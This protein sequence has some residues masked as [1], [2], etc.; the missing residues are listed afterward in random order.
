MFKFY[1]KIFFLLIFANF[2]FACQPNK[3]NEKI[4]FDLSSL[5]SI[6]INAEIKEINNNYDIL[7]SEPY[8]DHV[9]TIT[10]SQR[11]ESWFNNN[12]IN[13]GSENKLVITLLD[14]SIIR[15]EIQNKSESNNLLNSE[16]YLY[17]IVILINYV[18]YDDSG[19][20]L[21]TTEVKV[22][23]STTSG[24][25]I[26]INERNETLDQITFE[27][28]RDCSKKSVELLKKHMMGY[29]I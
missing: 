11:I 10:P 5:D 7:L 6:N 21:A 16:E 18:L 14:A 8:I 4:V 23:R 3:I 28:L 29:I 22:E 19:L 13:F 2:F 27:A 25:F 15:T 9:M 24:K 26:S 1:K 20:V 17:T 12:I